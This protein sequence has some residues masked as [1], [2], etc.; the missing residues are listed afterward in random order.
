M[1]DVSHDYED[2]KYFIG[3]MKKRKGTPHFF[4]NEELVEKILPYIKSEFPDVQITRV[5]ESQ[6]WFTITK[7]AQNVLVK[8]LKKIRA[9]Y[10]E[11]IK[12]LNKAIEGLNV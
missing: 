3:E 10:E 8:H 11:R 7:R 4:G 12:A 6:I 2:A 5:G 1:F 9:D